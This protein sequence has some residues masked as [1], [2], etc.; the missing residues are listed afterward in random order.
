M[1][2]LM[3]WRRLLRE[4]RLPRESAGGETYPAA[5]W[6]EQ[7]ATATMAAI[8]PMGMPMVFDGCW[9]MPPSAADEPKGREVP[10]D[11]AC[12]EDRQGAGGHPCS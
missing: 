3:R 12:G 2:L 5:A 1:G 11:S 6:E 9:L 8:A 7:R 4:N 10:T